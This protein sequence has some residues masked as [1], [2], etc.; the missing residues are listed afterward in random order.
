MRHVTPVEGEQDFGHSFHQILRDLIKDG[1]HHK[2]VIT[3]QVI[4]L[5]FE[6]K[7]FIM[8][9][10][11]NICNN[12]KQIGNLDFLRTKGISQGSVLSSLLCS[13]FYGNMENRY[14]TGVDK[15]GLL[16]RLIDDFLLVTPY[17][18]CATKFMQ[19][20]LSGECSE[21]FG[22]KVNPQKTLTN[23]EFIYEGQ[24]V[25]QLQGDWFPWCGFLFNV[26]TLEVKNDYQR[27]AATS[28]RYS[29]TLSFS[30]SDTLKMMKLKLIQAL[31]RSKGLV[32]FIDP[33]INSQRVI[34]ENIYHLFLLTAF[35][36][37]SYNQALPQLLKRSNTTKDLL[38]IILDIAPSFYF[39][40]KKTLQRLPA[41]DEF[42]LSLTA[43]KWL[44]VK[45]FDVKLSRYFGVYRKLI[46]VLRQQRRK[47][48][49]KLVS[50][51][52]VMWSNLI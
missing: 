28:F 3:N 31:H 40:A 27:Y 18:H 30:S 9:L 21:T 47:L 15:D 44:C 23:F 39:K 37:H 35:R 36:F 51:Y 41:E 1:S 19:V 22:C 24:P 33:L 11:A 34:T 46:I 45:A 48:A 43:M 38:G 50:A 49:R 17:L 7:G 42:P 25:Q 13:I 16:M 32:I 2:S 4:F 26:K 6:D 14:L 12:L 5:H 20:L 8:C 10:G 52:R 29:M